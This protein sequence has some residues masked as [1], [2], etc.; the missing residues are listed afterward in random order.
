M[1]AGFLLAARLLRRDTR[2]AGI[3]DEVVND[4]LARAALGALVGARLFYVLNHFSAYSSP[5]SST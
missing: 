2:R 4:I 1:S 3:A 5:R